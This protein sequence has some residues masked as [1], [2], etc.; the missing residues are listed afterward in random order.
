[1]TA[2]LDA[3]GPDGTVRLRYYLPMVNSLWFSAGCQGRKGCSHSAPTSVL[4]AIRAMGS[5]EATLGEL[6]QRLRCNQCGNREVGV[7]VQPDTRTA[8]AIERDGPALETRAGLP[9]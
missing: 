8:E 7:T 2:D 6:A 9:D 5:G 4:A 1:M 3:I